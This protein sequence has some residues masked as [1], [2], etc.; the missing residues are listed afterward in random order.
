MSNTTL[1]K[2]TLRKLQPQKK[3]DHRRRW[4]GYRLHSGELVCIA[5]TITHAVTTVRE[6]VRKTTPPRV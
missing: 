3:L 5:Q 4:D 2:T 1:T 6:Q